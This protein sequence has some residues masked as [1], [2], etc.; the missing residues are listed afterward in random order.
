MT[1]T[2]LSG[3]GTTDYWAVW[4]PQEQCFVEEGTWNYEHEAAQVA[5]NHNAGR[6][7]HHAARAYH[8]VHDMGV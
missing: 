8:V 5:A 6:N 3:E 7:P 4:C 2:G 1:D